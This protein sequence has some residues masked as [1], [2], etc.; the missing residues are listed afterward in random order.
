[1]S[2][3]RASYLYSGISDYFSGYGCNNNEALLYSFYGRGTTLRDILDELARDA[4]DGC[5]AERIPDGITD[6][7]IREAL[8]GMLTEQGRADY[9]SGAVAECAAEYADANG[10][11]RCEHCG[12]KIGTPHAYDCAVLVQLAE[13]GE[14]DDNYEVDVRVEE[15]DCADE[16]CGES[17]VIVVVLEWEVCEDCGAYTDVLVDGCVCADCAAGVPA[18]TVAQDELAANGYVE[19]VEQNDDGS[20]FISTVDGGNEC[21]QV[22]DSYSGW[23]LSCEDG[24]VLE[25]VRSC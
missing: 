9:E 4:W 14:I 20:V 8:I 16:D 1:M 21:F 24:R 6:E 15:E 13:D 25:F 10:L 19:I 12:E 3:V 22:R 2:K 18:V 17:P 11:G 7:Q 23:C 5:D